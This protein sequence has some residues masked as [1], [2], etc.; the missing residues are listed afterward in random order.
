MQ[1]HVV[2]NMEPVAARASM[3]GGLT[4][5]SQRA[6]RLA[7]CRLEPVYLSVRFVKPRFTQLE[8]GEDDC[9]GVEYRTR[10]PLPLSACC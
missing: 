8:R 1:L 9:G 10:L 5:L 3:H 2:G 6:A 7:R 4:S